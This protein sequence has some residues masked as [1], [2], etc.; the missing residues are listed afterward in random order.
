VAFANNPVN[1]TDPFGLC[2]G[3]DDDAWYKKSWKWLRNGALTIG[4]AFNFSKINSLSTQAF[5]NEATDPLAHERVAY[6]YG[7]YVGNAPLA[8]AMRTAGEVGQF[9]GYGTET[10]V[11][12]LGGNID[13][14]PGEYNPFASEYIADA[15]HD[16]EVT[17]SGANGSGL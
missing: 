5:A 16:V 11:N 13:I 12:S 17:V 2:E 4:R 3:G 8:G 14:L 9:I 15:V 10:I 1:F 7:A 6:A